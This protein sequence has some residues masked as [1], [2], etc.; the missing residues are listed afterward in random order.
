VT[1]Q[2]KVLHFFFE[3]VHGIWVLFG[4][5]GSN[6]L[7]L[8]D[9]NYM[10]KFMFSFSSFIKNTFFLK[11]YVLNWFLVRNLASF[12]FARLSFVVEKNGNNTEQWIQ[13]ANNWLRCMADGRERN[14]KPHY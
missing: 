5:D 1:I 2:G 8:K 4:F 14:Q 12:F 9:L 13:D 11:I 6:F 3:I 7:F 10:C